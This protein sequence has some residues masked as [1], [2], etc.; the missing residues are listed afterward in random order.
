MAWPRHKGTLL[1]GLV[2]LTP[3]LITVW[4]LNSVLQLIHRS[5]TPFLMRA[6]RITGL[7]IFDSTV[8]ELFAPLLSVML[9]VLS[10]FLLGKLTS[11]MLGRQLLSLLEQGMMRIPVGRTI[12]SATRQFLETF[13]SD[14]GRAFSEVVM[15]E[16]PRRGLWTMA[17]LTG[18]TRGEVAAR[19]GQKM[20]SVFIPTTPNPT[21]GWLLFVPVEDV[22]T[23]DMSV[24]DA[25]KM[26]I[27][28]GV[29]VPAYDGKD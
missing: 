18:E 2:I 1:T 19:S 29:L 20:V 8:M 12:Y 3:V 22:I 28:G 6:L 5:I 23:L 27:S 26:I 16:Y 21:S 7:S 14:G 15:V 9:A 13:S 25:F 11:N 4:V 10:I 24:D 17:L